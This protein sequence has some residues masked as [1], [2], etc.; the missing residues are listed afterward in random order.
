MI[1]PHSEQMIATGR[2]AI[3]I[4]AMEIAQSTPDDRLRAAKR[5]LEGELQEK[6]GQAAREEL[7]VLVPMNA[8]VAYY[9]KYGYTYHVLS[10]LESVARGKSIPEALPPVTSMF[11]AELKNGILTA[12][13]DLDKVRFPLG[14][15]MATG[16]EAYTVLNGKTATC[17]AGDWMIADQ[18]GVLSS[19]LRGP[20]LR[21]AITRQTKRVLYTAYTPVGVSEPMLRR[22]LSDIEALNRLFSESSEP[23]FRKIIHADAKGSV[24]FEAGDF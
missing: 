8:Y 9:K 6:F 20:D 15:L 23:D 2:C 1:E 4:L 13:H 14:C 7:K 18:E 11:M 19:I 5:Q 10:Q 21:T 12:G 24:L 3:G 16:G 22:H 17:V